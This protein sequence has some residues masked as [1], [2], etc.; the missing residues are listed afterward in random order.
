MQ[1]R[2]LR[3]ARQ[4]TQSRIR[5]LSA[6]TTLPWTPMLPAVAMDPATPMLPAVAMDPATPML[7][8]VA[9]DPATPILPAVAIEPP[10]AMLSVGER[11][12]TTA[13]EEAIPQLEPMPLQTVPDSPSPQLEPVSNHYACVNKSLPI[14]CWGCAST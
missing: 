4:A 6:V 8:A 12:S 3:H 14:G 2:H 13:V 7:P 5:T 9:M 1:R 11:G 10:T